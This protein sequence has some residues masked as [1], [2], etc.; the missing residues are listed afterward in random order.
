ML[1]EQKIDDAIG[2]G[3]DRHLVNVRPRQ[4]DQRFLN[5][6]NDGIPGM[7]RHPVTTIIAT[8]KNSK[9]ILDMGYSFACEF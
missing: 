8:T 1:C 5:R 3:I 6:Q 4:D 2:D 7:T 9:V